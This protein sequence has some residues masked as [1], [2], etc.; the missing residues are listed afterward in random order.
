MSSVSLW[1]PA[2]KTS[3]VRG[4]HGAPDK[5]LLELYELWVQGRVRGGDLERH[6]GL[7]E[8]QLYEWGKVNQLKA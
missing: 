7:S 3:K 6:Y 4:R 2:P 5:T 8:K 1:N